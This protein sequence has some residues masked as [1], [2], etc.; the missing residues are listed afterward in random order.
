[1]V[2][3]WCLYWQQPCIHS[4]LKT[5]DYTHRNIINA[6]DQKHLVSGVKCRFGHLYIQPRYGAALLRLVRGLLGGDGVGL[7]S[8]FQIAGKSLGLFKS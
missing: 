1:M 3:L 5:Y 8:N 2:W 4:Y 6:M 7:G